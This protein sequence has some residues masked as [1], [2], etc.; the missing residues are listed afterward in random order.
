MDSLSEMQGVE[1]T[2]TRKIEK[3]RS[4]KT[5]EE[6]EPFYFNAMQW[7]LDVNGWTALTGASG[8]TYHLFTALGLPKLTSVE[9]YDFIRYS[10]L[11][12]RGEPEG[13]QWYRVERIITKMHGHDRSI[14]LLLR[15]TNVTRRGTAIT[16]SFVTEE[17]HTLILQ[18]NHTEVIAGMYTKDTERA[19]TNIS[20]GTGVYSKIRHALRDVFAWTSK[21][22]EWDV[23]ITSIIQ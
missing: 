13:E 10:R 16:Y 3:R 14:A 6:A 12:L 7:L 5:F 8:G 18:L 4:F 9:E 22:N 15:P 11:N 1:Q 23:F 2:E 17:H 21:K 19:Q 20:S